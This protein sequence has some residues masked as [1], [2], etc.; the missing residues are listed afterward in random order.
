[1]WSYPVLALLSEGCPRP[2]GRLPTCYS[3][4]RRFTRE[5]KPSFSLDLHVLGAPLTF[6]LSQDQTLQLICRV[7]AELLFRVSAWLY[8]SFA[9]LWI[10]G[11]PPVLQMSPTVQF[12]K[13]G[14]G[15]C[16]PF[17]QRGCFVAAEAKLVKTQAKEQGKERRRAFD[18]SRFFP[19]NGTRNLRVLP[20]GV[21]TFLGLRRFSFFASRFRCLAPQK[22]SLDSPQG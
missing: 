14:P 7:S 9:L 17:S 18:F 5:P 10:F 15:P 6:A 2:K 4:V 20:L 8:R 12:S 21:N 16:R 19:A 13:N 11:D 22:S 3:P 1:V